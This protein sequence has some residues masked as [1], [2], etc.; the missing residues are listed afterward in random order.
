MKRTFLFFILFSISCFGV[1]GGADRGGGGD[2]VLS[3]GEVYLL[4]L[5]EKEFF[6]LENEEVYTSN[7]RPKLLSLEYIMVEDHLKN[8][9][10]D[11]GT[12]SSYYKKHIYLHNYLHEALSRIDWFFT[13]SSIPEVNDEGVDV[14]EVPIR[15]QKYQVAYQVNNIVIINKSLYEQM[16]LKNQEAL[17]WHEVFLNIILNNAT[18]VQLENL[19]TAKI[20]TFCSYFSSITADQIELD[21]LESSLQRLGMRY[22]T[23]EDDYLGGE[24]IYP[25]PDFFESDFWINSQEMLERIREIGGQLS[26]IASIDEITSTDPELLRS[27]VV[28]VLEIILQNDEILRSEV[29]IYSAQDREK[30]REIN[31]EEALNLQALSRYESNKTLLALQISTNRV[32]QRRSRGLIRNLFSR[33]HRHTAQEVASVLAVIQLVKD[34]FERIEERSKRT[35]NFEF[36]LLEG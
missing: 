20:R 5:Y 6:V 3:G 29:G 26:G 27:E 2:G 36:V 31:W 1:E 15:G 10:G 34:E 14:Y 19:T 12:S 17:I 33:G 30:L 28:P 9:R 35:R 25:G 7:I 21:Q 24:N 4:D 8:R 11:L 32:R 16:N 18:E 23:V 22:Y 13:S